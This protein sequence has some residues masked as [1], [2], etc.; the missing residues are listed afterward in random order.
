MRD[1]LD[2]YREFVPT[3]AQYLEHIED[4]GIR[5]AYPYVGLAGEAGE[6]LNVLKKIYRDDG[7]KLTPAR[8]VQMEDELGDVMWYWMACCHA[9]NVSP[10]SIILQNME[11]LKKRREEGSIRGE[12]DRQ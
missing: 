4:K 8:R 1:I 3:T 7:G 6:L 9:L 12:R 2:E 11:K 10:Q 5:E